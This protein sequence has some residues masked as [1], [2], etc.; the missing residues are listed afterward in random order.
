MKKPEI[1]YESKSFIVINKPAGLC[2][3]GGKG[4]KIS[5]DKIIE[6]RL[7]I[8][9]FLVHRLDRETSGLIIVAK[10]KESAAGFSK[11]FE[12]RQKNGIIK[13]YLAICKGKPASIK[14][15]IKNDLIIHGTV[16]KCETRW[17]QIEIFK[18]SA[19]EEYS[20]LELELGT[21]RLHQIRRHLAMQGNPII[22]DD[23]YGDFTLNHKLRKTIKLRNLLLHASQI[24][25]PK[26][27]CAQNLDLISSL[28]IHFKQ[29]AAQ[30]AAP[31]ASEL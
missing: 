20:M 16:K 10:N 29:F 21:G 18:D 31:N 1:L 23:K 4:I 14:G 27:P 7:G 22:G 17:R 2:V 13:R 12:S 15:L 8:R 25:I 3:Q 5:L 28:P 19:G 30:I 11:L 9:P 6:M 24:I 26:S